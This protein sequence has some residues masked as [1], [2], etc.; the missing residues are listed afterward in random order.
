MGKPRIFPV[1]ETGISYSYLR[2]DD[3]RWVVMRMFGGITVVLESYG[4][5]SAAKKRA[6]QLALIDRAQARKSA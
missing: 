4:K 6:E 1:G 5:E 3:G 2:R